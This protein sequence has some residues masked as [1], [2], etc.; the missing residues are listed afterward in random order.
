MFNIIFVT[1]HFII[2]PCARLWLLLR[3]TTYFHVGVRT[4]GRCSRRDS[5]FYLPVVVRG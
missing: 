1:I 2:P 5:T 3:S 4:L